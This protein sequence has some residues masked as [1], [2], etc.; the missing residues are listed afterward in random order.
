[1]LTSR[2][3]PMRVDAADALLDGGRLQA[4]S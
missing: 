1:M 4:R 3:C 2:D